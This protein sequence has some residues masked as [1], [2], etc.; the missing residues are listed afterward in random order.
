MNILLCGVGGQGIILASQV[1]G[2]G[3][4]KIG[5]HVVISEIHGMAQRG[6]SVYTFVRIDEGDAPIPPHGCID[7][8][9]SFERIELLRYLDFMSGET[10]VLI[11]D[12]KIPPIGVSLQK[13]PY[14]EIEEIVAEVGKITAKI[15]H[16]DAEKLA[17]EAGTKLA[18][19]S[20]MLGA[21]AA[22]QGFPIPKAVVL[23]TLLSKLTEKVREV[24]RKAFE[25][26]Y[27]VAKASTAGH[28][29]SP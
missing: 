10:V 8:A 4:I 13:K 26:G 27:E 17:M 28:P 20:V 25:S 15:L 16:F 19:N 14:P 23:D 2:E 3:S 9:V 6:G 12:A 29:L 21:I 22:L 7:V 5:K 24:N 11:N 18:V 1:L